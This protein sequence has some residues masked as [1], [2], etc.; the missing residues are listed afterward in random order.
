LGITQDAITASYIPTAYRATISQGTGSVTTRINASGTR[1]F[2]PLP[3][4]IR[5]FQNFA[6]MRSWM[7]TNLFVRASTNSNGYEYVVSTT[8]QP[9]FLMASTNTLYRVGDPVLAMVGGV[10]GRVIIGGTTTCLD[11]DGSC[12]ASSIASYFTPAANPTQALPTH[13]DASDGLS[14]PFSVRAHSF[15]NK[16]WIPLP[17]IQAASHGGNTVTTS[18]PA[19]TSPQPFWSRIIPCASSTPGAACFT[20]PNPLTGTGSWTSCVCPRPP[21]PPATTNIQ[22]TG[23][24]IDTR[25]GFSP[26]LGGIDLTDFGNVRSAEWRIGCSDPDGPDERIALAPSG[27]QVRLCS[28]YH[29]EM[30]CTRHAESHSVRGGI[31]AVRTGNGPANDQS[32]CTI[33]TF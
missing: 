6:A 5:S 2:L 21:G 29:A 18:W 27:E 11:P 25:A 30:V 26:I 28:A 12:S 19:D 22:L 17:P 24:I 7:V 4:S 9:F 1:Y 23:Q 15:Y 14:D 8:D 33:S 31:A 10:T 16:W 20:G 3:D 32:R 13:F